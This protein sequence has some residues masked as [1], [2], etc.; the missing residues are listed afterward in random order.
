MVHNAGLS[1]W[2]GVCPLLRPAL[3]FCLAA[4][5][6]VQHVDRAEGGSRRDPSVIFDPNY[7]VQRGPSCAL[8]SGAPV[9]FPGGAEQLQLPTQRWISALAS[10]DLRTLQGVLGGPDFSQMMRNLPDAWR[11]HSI[12]SLTAAHFDILSAIDAESCSKTYSVQVGNMDVRSEALALESASW[13]CGAML[14]QVSDELREAG[15]EV[16]DLLCRIGDRDVRREKFETI[17]ELLSAASA[18]PDLELTFAK[19]RVEQIYLREV[20]ASQDSLRPFLG[21]ESRGVTVEASELVAQL[22]QQLGSDTLFVSERVPMLFAGDGG[23]GSHLH[24]D[25]KP[26]LQFCHVLH[27]RKFFTVAP[28]GGRPPGAVVPWRCASPEVQLSTST[29]GVEVEEYLVQPE[30]KMPSR[31]S[32]SFGARWVWSPACSELIWSRSSKT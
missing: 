10:R 11:H 7:F 25:R 22:G 26:L 3:V 14:R 32:G 2:T 19:V 21:E 5:A 27:G 28:N 16:G 18:A 1:T 30:N 9:L 24:I 20:L 17:Q 23:T 31:R 8:S 13:T 12:C 4:V 15:C 29:S 6:A